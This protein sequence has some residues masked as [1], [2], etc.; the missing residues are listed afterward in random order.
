MSLIPLAP[1]EFNTKSQENEKKTGKNKTIKKQQSNE[2]V[3]AVISKIHNNIESL[4]NEDNDMTDFSPPPPPESAGDERITNRVSNDGDNSDEPETGDVSVT[5]EKFNEMNSSKT[6][7]EQTYFQ[8]SIPYYTQMSEQP[9]SNQTEIM[10]K[11][12]K[13]LYLLEEHQD[14]K[15]GHV[16]EELLLYS[17]VGVFMIF[18]VDSF[19]RAGKYVR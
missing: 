3:N 6:G 8:N 16:T 11:M 5:L 2:R 13:I 1:A 19:A 4:D 12:D 9:L 7:D 10:K 14:Q 15:T 17:F 18:I